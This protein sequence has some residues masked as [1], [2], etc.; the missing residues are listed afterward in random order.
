MTKLVPFKK[1]HYREIVGNSDQKYLAD[2]VTDEDLE[3]VEQNPFSRSC[4][5]EEKLLGVGGIILSHEQRGEAWGVVA[6]G[7]REQF[8][9]LHRAVKGYLESVP[10]RR[11]EAAV[12]LDFEPGHRWVKAL[13]FTL[14]AAVMRAH[15]LEG[16]DAAL[17]AITKGGSDGR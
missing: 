15:S 11:V 9:R 5:H 2:Y 10:V 4:F 6:K 7:N 1:E 12:H 17:Y 14:E 8:I 3:A 16:K 13:G